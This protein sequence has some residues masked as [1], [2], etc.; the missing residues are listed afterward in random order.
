MAAV[1]PVR[2]PSLRR[3]ACVTW[4]GGCKPPG[5]ATAAALRGSRS[6]DTGEAVLRGAA[7]YGQPP[8]VLERGARVR[9]GRCFDG[10]GAGRLDEL[11]ADEARGEQ[12]QDRDHDEA[13]LE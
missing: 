11:P 7:P 9:R 5:S 13:Q 8:L 3:V 2:T 4:S 1:A 10:S 12:I 6:S